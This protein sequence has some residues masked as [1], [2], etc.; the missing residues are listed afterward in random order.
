MIRRT[1]GILGIL[2]ILIM[3]HGCVPNQDESKPVSL[4]DPEATSMALTLFN[5]LFELS[6]DHVLLGTDY[7]FG[8]G[9]VGGTVQWIEGM[10]F[11][12]NQ[13]KNRILGENA[14]HLLNISSV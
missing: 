12:S 14:G 11:L 9:I 6:A 13:D 10:S 2:G 1:L 3:V 7:P 5:K 8:D 4:S